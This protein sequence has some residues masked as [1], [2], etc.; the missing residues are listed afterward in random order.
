MLDFTMSF[1]MQERE[2]TTDL[3]ILPHYSRWGQS[4]SFIKKDLI[5]LALFIPTDLQDTKNLMNTFSIWVCM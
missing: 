2:D 3:L 5:L 4:I 1:P